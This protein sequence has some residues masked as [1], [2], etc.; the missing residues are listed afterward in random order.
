MH[1]RLVVIGFV[2]SA[3]SLALPALADN[4]LFGPSGLLRVPSAQVVSSPGVVGSVYIVNNVATTVDMAKRQGTIVEDIDSME[5]AGMIIGCSWAEGVAHL[6]GIA[7]QW[8]ASCWARMLDLLLS[9][10]STGK[11][12]DEVEAALQTE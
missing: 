6:M 9:S 11:K 10:V 12:F 5:L 3:V 7:G 4:S 1:Y 8:D 2:I